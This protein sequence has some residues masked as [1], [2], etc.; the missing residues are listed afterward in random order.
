MASEQEDSSQPS[1]DSTTGP[2][3]E[4]IET[5]PNPAANLL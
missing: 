2:Y 5:T 1:Q 3:S 4:P